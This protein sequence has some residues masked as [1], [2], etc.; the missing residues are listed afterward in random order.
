MPSG[1]MRM[2]GPNAPK[3]YH[4]VTL[5]FGLRFG[6]AALTFAGTADRS[7]LIWVGLTYMIGTRLLPMATTEATFGQVLRTTG[8][9]AAPGGVVRVLQDAGVI[10]DA[11]DVVASRRPGVF[12]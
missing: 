3:S 4:V 6:L 12:V 11:P 8:F 10:G 9:S 2:K 7:W 1:S 5:A